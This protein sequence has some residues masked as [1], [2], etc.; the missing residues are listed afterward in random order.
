VPVA[1]RVTAVA[2]LNATETLWFDATGGAGSTVKDTFATLLAPPAL[3]AV[4]VKLS[5]PMKAVAGV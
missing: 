5:V 3:L 4:K 1:V 2:V